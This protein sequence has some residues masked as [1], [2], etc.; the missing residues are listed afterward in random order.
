LAKKAAALVLSICG[1]LP[2]SA[3]GEAVFVGKATIPSDARGRSGRS[4]EVA[5]RHDRYEARKF[6]PKGSHP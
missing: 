5:A 1:V 2:T 4:D 6:D 3:V